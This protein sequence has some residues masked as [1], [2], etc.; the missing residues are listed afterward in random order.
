MFTIYNNYS[1]DTERMVEDMGWGNGSH[2]DMHERGWR[3]F[4]HNHIL[5]TILSFSKLAIEA[6]TAATTI[7]IPFI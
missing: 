1:N 3:L 4:V 6:V 5:H 7:R 2:P